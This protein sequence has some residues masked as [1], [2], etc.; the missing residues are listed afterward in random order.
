[1]PSRGLRLPEF[2]HVGRM[3]VARLSALG[4]GL[5][6]HSAAGSNKSLKNLND[7]FR[8]R[9]RDLS[10]CSA[11]AQPLKMGLIGCPETTVRN[12]HY[13]CVTTEKSAVLMKYVIACEKCGCSYGSSL[14]QMLWN[15]KFQCA[16][17]Q[18][19]HP[20]QENPVHILTI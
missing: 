19:T 11:V 15:I 5:Q 2:L 3:E 9:T 18:S 4:S 8:N 7:T 17:H 13:R 1:M 12:C 14:P 10:A 20:H 6:E 16:S